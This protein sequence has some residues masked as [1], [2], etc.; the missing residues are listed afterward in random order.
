MSKEKVAKNP[1]V[2]A[3]ILNPWAGSGYQV[4]QIVEVSQKAL[5]NMRAHLREAT[6]EE[7]KTGKV[8]K[9]NDKAL[10]D[11]VS[12]LEAENSQ[13]KSDLEDLKGRLEQAEKN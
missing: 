11:K 12:M 1:L 5:I 8:V 3:V 7:C 9:S 2:K 4:G 13:L 6:E 10:K